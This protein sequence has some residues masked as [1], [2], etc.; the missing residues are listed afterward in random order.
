MISFFLCFVR[1]MGARHLLSSRLPRG[2]PEDVFDPITQVRETTARISRV[3][4]E[5][6]NETRVDI[7]E[8]CAQRSYGYLEMRS[9][10]QRSGVFE[11]LGAWGDWN[12]DLPMTNDPSSWRMIVA[13]RGT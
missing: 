8:R 12:T 11:W 10:A 7:I 2:L 13:L 9:L 3:P 5:G 4:N 6:S 1:K